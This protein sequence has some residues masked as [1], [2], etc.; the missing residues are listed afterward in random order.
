VQR[1][2]A[3][4]LLVV[5][6]AAGCGGGSKETTT[7]VA[8]NDG[9][10]PSSKADFIEL[11][12]AICRNHQSRRDDLESRAAALGPLD[13]PAK[14]RQAGRLL[15]QESQNLRLEIDELQS[16]Q[17]APPSPVLAP[18]FSAERVRAAAIDGWADA[19]DH[20]DE[21][22][23]RRGQLRVGVVAA[24]TRRRARRYGFRVCGG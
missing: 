22:R 21:A 1:I 5:V 3:P 24:A 13:S 14:A 12:D 2:A 20:L 10:S 9:G 19:Y 8:P 7:Q 23:I 15:R 6:L 4:A 17:P 18:F 11:A 16:H